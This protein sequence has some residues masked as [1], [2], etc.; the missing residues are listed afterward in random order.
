MLTKIK[1][2][3]FVLTGGFAWVNKKTKELQF[4]IVLTDAYWNQKKYYFELQDLIDAWIVSA[5]DNDSEIK[6]EYKDF[7]T[8]NFWKKIEVETTETLKI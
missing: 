3:E 2:Q 8:K 1:T 7:L 4:A 6:Q 5:S